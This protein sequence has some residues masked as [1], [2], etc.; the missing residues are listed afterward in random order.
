MGLDALQV[1]WLMLR[2]F[3]SLARR[4]ELPSLA[5]YAWRGVP[6]RI[7]ELDTLLHAMGFSNKG[8]LFCL[9]FSFF[10]WLWPSS[11]VALYFSTISMKRA[12]SCVVRSKKKQQETFQES[13]LWVPKMQ[14]LLVGFIPHSPCTYYG[15]K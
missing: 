12:I 9:L 4:R 7:D 11:A 15:Q 14:Q 5:F 6:S 10:S 8:L 13:G 1:R 3:W 2:G